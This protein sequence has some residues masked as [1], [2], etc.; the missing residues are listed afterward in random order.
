MAKKAGIKKFSKE[1]LLTEWESYKKWYEK[2]YNK[3]MALSGMSF[4]YARSFDKYMEWR[5]KVVA[6][7]A[8]LGIFYTKSSDVLSEMK[9]LSYEVTKRQVEHL[10]GQIQDFIDSGSKEAVGDFLMRFG[11]E[12]V[13]DENGDI[14]VDT[15]AYETLHGNIAPLQMKTGKNHGWYGELADMVEYINT[16]GFT[17]SWNS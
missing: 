7:Q 5:D 12:L 2:Q 9:R 4:N 16:L 10:L 8:Q 6:Q 1:A 13:Y 11:G 3:D 14:D 15:I 17:I